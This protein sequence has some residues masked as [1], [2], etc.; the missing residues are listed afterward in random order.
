MTIATLVLAAAVL[1]NCQLN[2]IQS[3]TRGRG[4]R[5]F[6]TSGGGSGLLKTF[7]F[8][9]DNLN[10][11]PR[12]KNGYLPPEPIDYLPPTPPP[13]LPPDKITPT[14]TSGPTY[15]P[16][17]TTRPPKSNYTY[18]PTMGTFPPTIY[19]NYTTRRTTTYKPIS[20]PITLKPLEPVTF[21]TT[22]YYYNVPEN[23]LIEDLRRSKFNKK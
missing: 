1:I 22:G 5:P 18:M 4:G 3:R 17:S 9:K 6:K 15:L 23:P 14:S 11:R 20:V 16:P 12:G 7:T 2:D 8:D 10:E 13:Y 21:P 19:Y